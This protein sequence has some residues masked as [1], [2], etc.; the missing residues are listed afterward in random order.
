MV[1]AAT[2]LAPAADRVVFAVIA[3]APAGAARGEPRPLGEVAAVGVAVA[4]A[5]C[6]RSGGERSEFKYSSSSNYLETEKQTLC[7]PNDHIYSGK[8]W[9]PRCC[10]LQASKD[11]RCRAGRT[12][13]SDGLLCGEHSDTCRTPGRH[14]WASSVALLTGANPGHVLAFVCKPKIDPGRCCKA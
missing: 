4:L 9:T 13:H 10:C 1:P 14:I 7:S 12:S 5:L 11:D 6:S 8:R 2:A 3:D